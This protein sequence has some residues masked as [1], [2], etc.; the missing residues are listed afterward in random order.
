MRTLSAIRDHAARTLS[1]AQAAR[2]TYREVS[3]GATPAT[4]RFAQVTGYQSRS[5]Q[6]NFALR[7]KL[8]K[9][10]GTLEATEVIIGAWS[11][12]RDPSGNVGTQ[13]LTVCF[14]PV[15]VGDSIQVTATRPP[16]F[17]ASDVYPWY[18]TERFVRYCA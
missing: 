16:Q 15:E 6:A 13:D 18:C 11:Y 2:E 3:P 1:R 9:S 17:A 14:P 5:G 12:P 10:D 8:Y 4:T 7:A